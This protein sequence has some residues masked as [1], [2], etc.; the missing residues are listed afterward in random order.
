MSTTRALD[1]AQQLSANLLK[2]LKVHQVLRMR[3]LPL[4]IYQSNL[5]ALEVEPTNAPGFESDMLRLVTKI[6]KTQPNI[7]IIV[8][9][10]LRQNIR[11]IT[12]LTYGTTKS[13]YPSRCTRHAHAD[14]NN[15]GLQSIFPI[16]WGALSPLR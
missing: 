2:P 5:V 3:E 11:K 4:E 13:T 12:W 10:S 15:M 14:T 6:M 8:P 7:A 9:Q 1:A 16:V